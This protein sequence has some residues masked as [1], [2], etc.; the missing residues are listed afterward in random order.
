MNE[1]FEKIKS[2]VKGREFKTVN[3]LKA[4]IEDAT[5]EPLFDTTND[6]EALD[7]CMVELG[8]REYKSEPIGR[9]LV[10]TEEMP[11]VS[12]TIYENYEDSG[13]VDY[14][15]SYSLIY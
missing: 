2:A 6:A 7:L 15:Y 5:S 1:I 11:Q 14:V 13:S 8:M 9:L 10:D 3:E 4:A 12:I